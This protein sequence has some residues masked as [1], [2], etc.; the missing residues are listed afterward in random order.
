M[1]HFPDFRAGEKTF[2]LLAQVAGRA[3]RGE[4]PGTVH[5]Q[6]FHPMHPAIRHAAHHDVTGFADAELEFRRVFF[7][8]PYSELAAIVVSSEDRDRA[9]AAADELG[10]GFEKTAAAVRRS[11]PAPA[12]FERLQGR[13]RYQLLLRATDR[14]GVLAALEAVVPERPAAGVQIAVDVDPQDLL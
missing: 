9:R 4:S 7:Y 10:R 8:P 2:Q 3:G 14:R 6:T 1:L 11:G 13:W 12:P 5:V